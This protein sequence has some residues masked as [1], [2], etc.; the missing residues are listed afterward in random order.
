ML[1]PGRLIADR[2]A[3]GEAARILDLHQGSSGLSDGYLFPTCKQMGSSAKLATRCSEIHRMF[4][5]LAFQYGP[6]DRN[7]SA[8]RSSDLTD[9]GGCFATSFQGFRGAS[10]GTPFFS[11]ATRC[12]AG[13]R[14]DP[15]QFVAPVSRMHVI[16]TRSSPVLGKVSSMYAK[17]AAAG[18]RPAV[19]VSV[20]G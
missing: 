9:F 10:Q 8:V 3:R 19:V 7:R 4:D 5:R 18:E 6:A 1:S 13:Q 16:P 20:R 17:H 12:S 14:G 15:R 11:S 2:L